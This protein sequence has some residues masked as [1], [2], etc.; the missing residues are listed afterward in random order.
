MVVHG[1]LH[2]LADFTRVAPPT[3]GAMKALQMHSLAFII[4]Y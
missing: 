1:Q 4:Q 3:G 2:L